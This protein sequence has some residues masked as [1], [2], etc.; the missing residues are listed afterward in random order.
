M[1]GLYR[2]RQLWEAWAACGHLG[3][4]RTMWQGPGMGRERSHLKEKQF[5]TATGHAAQLG[6]EGGYGGDMVA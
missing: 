2:F 3:Q 1:G 4:E 5:C 6:A